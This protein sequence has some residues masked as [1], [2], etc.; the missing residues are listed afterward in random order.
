M[1]H[2]II[3]GLFTEGPT[4]VRFLESIIK[5][6][7]DEVAFEC[8]GDI[9]V[10][11]VIWQ[12]RTE[13]KGRFK[14]Q[15]REAARKGHEEYGVMV[16]CVHTDADSKDDTHT[17]ENKINPAVIHIQQSKEDI[18]RNIVAVVPVQMTEAWM[19]ADTQLLKE[20]I[21]TDKSDSELGIFRDPEEYAD[22]KKLIKNIIAAV[23]QKEGKRRRHELKI[24]D[25]YLP[26]GQKIKM[27]KLEKLN[28]YRKFKQGVRE[29]YRKMKYLR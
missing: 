4:D 23:R 10:Y 12:I 19:L 7:F 21:G 18:C 28:S 25:L 26:T 11:D 6:T 9:L 24:A 5:R 3:I 29:A 16:L 14:E 27:E 20:E 1:T 8:E 13:K 2:Q 15:V 17:F 22:P